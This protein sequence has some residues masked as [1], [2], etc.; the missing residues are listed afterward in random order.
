MYHHQDF[1][2]IYISSCWLA[3]L[4][5]GNGPGS[6]LLLVQPTIGGPP[7]ARDRQLTIYQMR[8][9]S[10]RWS[11]TKLRRNSLW[12]SIKYAVCVWTSLVD[13]IDT[14]LHFRWGELFYFWP[15]E[16]QKVHK[17]KLN[18]VFNCQCIRPCVSVSVWTSLESDT[19]LNLFHFSE[20]T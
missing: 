13:D 8:S 15:P 6:M 20:R 10:W 19:S 3:E 9:R 5:N 17:W 2:S 14:S 7:N 4:L 11:N 18:L 1:G 12:S 16:Q